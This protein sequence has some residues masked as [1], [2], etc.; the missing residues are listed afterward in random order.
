MNR[1]ICQ[2]SSKWLFKLPYRRLDASFRPWLNVTQHRHIQLPTS[3]PNSRHNISSPK[4]F[5]QNEVLDRYVE[6]SVNP[7]T[8]QHLVFFGRHM[9][10][11]RLI[12]SA[13][14]VRKEITIRLA[15]RIRDFQKL[16]FIVGTNPHIEVGCL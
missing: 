4:N 9:T 1:S 11:N 14:Y 10:D 13:N 5:Y 15:H 16:P 3:W 7:N 8:I 12:H 2:L 6:K